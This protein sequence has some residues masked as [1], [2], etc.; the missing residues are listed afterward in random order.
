MYTIIMKKKLFKFLLK[1]DSSQVIIM[2]FTE[3]ILG[4]ILSTASFLIFLKISK[5]VLENDWY[6]F[7]VAV[8]NFIYSLRTPLLTSVMQAI[9]VLGGD[10]IIVFTS[11]V[12]IFLV[13]KRYKTEA[14]IFLLIIT[15][16]II[17]NLFLKYIIARPRP[18][19]NPLLVLTTFSFPSGHSMNSFVFYLT[20]AFFI[21]RFTR[22]KCLAIVISAI[23]ICLV[24]LISF[25]RVYLGVHYPTD[26]LAGIVGGFWWFITALLIERTMIFF[27]L[28]KKTDYN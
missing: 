28:F 11:I 20:V 27:K 10:I 1:V 16:G 9:T 8:S 12:I 7:D 6:S 14:V 15:M 21:F 19:I 13:L 22:N 5:N 17:I 18:D 24:L 2:L 25:S 4:I 3:V 26:V 23:S